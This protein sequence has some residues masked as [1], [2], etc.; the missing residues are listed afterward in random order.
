MLR[1]R[2][3]PSETVHAYLRKNG[4]MTLAELASWTGLTQ[5]TLR[6]HLRLHREAYASECDAFGIRPWR[7]I[8]DI[9]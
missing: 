9:Q 3:N 4:P 1:S 5:S 7:V 6:S 8:G 2:A